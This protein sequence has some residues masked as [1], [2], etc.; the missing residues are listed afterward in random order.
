MATLADYP[1]PA[2]PERVGLPRYQDLQE[3]HRSLRGLDVRLEHGIEDARNALH[4]WRLARNKKLSIVDKI[5]H[6]SKWK[7][8]WND[9][10]EV[11]RAL[12][13]RYNKNAVTGSY[14][15]LRF[16]WSDGDGKLR[17]YL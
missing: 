12:I 7:K 16:G 5:F 6:G 10:S 13:T 14:Y 3:Y 15:L 17:G 4:N 11:I 9:E 1:Q 8:H 2:H